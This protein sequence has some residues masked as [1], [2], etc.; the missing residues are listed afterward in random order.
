MLRYYNI[1]GKLLAEFWFL[2]S[3]K[4]QLWASARRRHHPFVHFFYSTVIYIIVLL[5]I[6]GS[7]TDWK[8]VSSDRQATSTEAAT[9]NSSEPS[10]FSSNAEITGEVEENDIPSDEPA[11][12]EPKPESD[13]VEQATNSAKTEIPTGIRSA[14]NAA[15]QSGETVRWE[16]DG[17]K[18]YAVPSDPEPSTG[19]RRVHYS[20]DSRSGWTSQPETICP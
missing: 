14:M 16:T 1:P 4:G 6:I 19:C 17:A 18:G 5:L 11:T 20:D 9:E 12:V 10:Y 2:W 7:L 8:S 3:K 13:V 15:F